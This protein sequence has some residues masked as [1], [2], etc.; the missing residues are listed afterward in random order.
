ML[1]SRGKNPE[2]WTSF[3]GSGNNEGN[4]FAPEFRAKRLRGLLEELDFREPERLAATGQV[5]SAKFKIGVEAGIRRDSRSG[6]LGGDKANAPGSTPDTKWQGRGS[7]S[8]RE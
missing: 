2:P 5:Y 7:Q 4:V 8:G 1:R 3:F 6:V